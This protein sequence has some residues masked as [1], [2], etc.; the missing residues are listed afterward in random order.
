MHVGGDRHLARGVA[1]PLQL[2]RFGTGGAVA[3]RPRDVVTGA[4]RESEAE[5]RAETDVGGGRQDDV[6]RDRQ[7]RLAGAVRLSDQQLRHADVRIGQRRG[8]PHAQHRRALPRRRAQH[9]VLSRG[10]GREQTPLRHAGPPDVGRPRIVV[11]DERVALEERAVI[12]GVPAVAVQIGR[13]QQAVGV[14]GAASGAAADLDARRHARHVDH[15][16]AAR[17]HGRVREGDEPAPAIA[18]RALFLRARGSVEQQRRRAAEHPRAG[19]QA[20]VRVRGAVG[21]V[22]RRAVAARPRGAATAIVSAPARPGVTTGAAAPGAKAADHEHQQR[23][24]HRSE[25]RR[26]Q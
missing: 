1:R 24:R 2:Q 11:V 26:L 10:V 22:A 3:R 4:G 7:Q 12:R 20:A 13:Q 15:V 9:D 21:T 8:E 17:R 23:E 6:V 25:R 16:Q 14:G 18:R 5:G 19:D